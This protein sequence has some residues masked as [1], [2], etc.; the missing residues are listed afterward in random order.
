[1]AISKEERTQV[2]C[3]RAIN[4]VRSLSGSY[5]DNQALFQRILRILIKM[6]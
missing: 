3:L 4:R 5:A 6:F 2:L 1:V